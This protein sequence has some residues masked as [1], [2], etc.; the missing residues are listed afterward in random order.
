MVDKINP[1]MGQDYVVSSFMVVV[2]GG[3]GKLAGAIIA[4]FGIG[5]VGN[6]LEPFLSSIKSFAATSSVLS[7]VLVLAMVV[8]FLQWKPS[9]LFPPKGRH[10]DA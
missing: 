8:V 6:Y 2:V 7:K 9:G 4:G 1:N 3:V 5:A 10:A